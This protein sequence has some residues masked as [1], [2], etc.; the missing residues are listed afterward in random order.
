MQYEEPN[1]VVSFPETHVLH[2]EIARERKL[3]AFNDA[4]WQSMRRLFTTASSDPAVRVVVLSAR[5]ER[6]FSAGLD[7]ASTS[8]V[9]GDEAGDVARRATHLRRHILD[10]Q[11]SI[12]AIAR[13]ERPVLVALHGICYGLAIDIASAADVRY[14]SRCARLC[15]KEVD[16]GLAAD[17]GSL[18]RLPKVVGNHSW[19][20]EAAM[21]AR[22]F[23]ADEALAQG[24]VS[25]V[26]ADRQ[27]CIAM[28]LATARRMASKS[29]VAVQGTKFLLDYSREHTVDEG[30]QM[31]AVW[32]A[33]MLQ[34]DDV[35]DAIK[36]VLA[37]KPATFA[38][39]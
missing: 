4:L 39:L 12:T 7:L 19:L 5:G 37:K 27:A 16:I 36:G 34:T 32:N 17:I 3:N 20:R 23:D 1:F 10:F 14:A 38:K 21:T 29:P 11:S 8:I 24:L 33:G 30:L 18:Q 9:Q 22:V 35:A 13:C 26:A 28:A 25:A 31:T 2:I 6:A 15:I